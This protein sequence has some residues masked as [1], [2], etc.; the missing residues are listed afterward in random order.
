MIKWETTLYAFG[1]DARRS[2]LSLLLSAS[3]DPAGMMSMGR[4]SLEDV[5]LALCEESLIERSVWLRRED[6]VSDIESGLC[7]PVS[8]LSLYA[9]TPAMAVDAVIAVTKNEGAR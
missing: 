1:E 8:G 7:Y 2:A 3:A 4:A 9:I 5:A 6:A